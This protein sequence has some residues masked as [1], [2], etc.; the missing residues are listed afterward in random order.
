MSCKNCGKS[1]NGPKMTANIT[2]PGRTR[3][4]VRFSKSPVAPSQETAVDSGSSDGVSE[5]VVGSLQ[6]DTEPLASVPESSTTVE[7]DLF[8][9]L[10]GGLV[11]HPSDD[12]LSVSG[13]ES[14]DI[15]E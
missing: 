5:S 14:E 6:L 1:V 11:D 15:A 3:P 7:R 12:G 13:G 10:E 2:V 8:V 4:H 9:P